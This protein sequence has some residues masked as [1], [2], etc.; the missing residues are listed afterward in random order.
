MKAIIE[1]RNLSKKFG[2]KTV[3]DRIDFQVNEGEVFGYLGPNG[4][5]KTT[6][7]RII[8]GLLEPTAGKTLVMGQNLGENED[9]RRRVGVLLENDGLY[10]LLSAY[11]NLNYY[12]QLYWVHD[13]EQKIK[14][15]LDF[16]QLSDKKNDKV[17]NFSKGMKRKLALSRSLINDPAILFFDEPSAGL[18]PS[19]SR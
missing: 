9:L 7:M 4:A 17:G 5:G 18:D 12:A 14:E 8:L 1:I 3:L 6:T 15:L 19:A 11:D 16:A 10:G 2:E 13:R